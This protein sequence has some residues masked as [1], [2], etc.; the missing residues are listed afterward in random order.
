[1]VSGVCV[2]GP[3]GLRR[4][5]ALAATQAGK[6][7]LIRQ[8]CYGSDAGGLSAWDRHRPI[9]NCGSLRQSHW[10]CSFHSLGIAFISSS[11]FVRPRARRRPGIAPVGRDDHL[12]AAAPLS[13]HRNGDGDGVA[14]EGSAVA[15]PPRVDRGTRGERS[16]GPVASTSMRARRRAISH[17][18]EI[19]YSP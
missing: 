4:A 19:K 11:S 5:P 18:P 1:M 9:A 14:V 17:F 7:W 13:G 15:A 10:R 16:E 3:F 2:G 12:P 8:P 6:N